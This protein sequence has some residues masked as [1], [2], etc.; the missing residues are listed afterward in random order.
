MVPKSL[1]GRP[2]A[3]SLRTAPKHVARPLV[4][5]LLEDR[6]LMAV[7]LQY[8][9]NLTGPLEFQGN[10]VSFTQ[11]ITVPDRP[12]PQVQTFSAEPKLSGF[13]AGVS[14]VTSPANP[15]FGP[16]FP[17]IVSWVVTFTVSGV[18]DGTYSGHVKARPSISNVA[19]GP[20]TAVTLIVANNQPPIADAGGPYLISEGQSLT[21]N[22]SGSFDPDGDPLT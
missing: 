9:S 11:I 3:G 14:V 19:E 12:S 21:L 15:T 18:A 7:S 2:S 10:P 22:G 6:T 17:S 20:G 8:A 16:V 5:E 1:K 13:P 4:V